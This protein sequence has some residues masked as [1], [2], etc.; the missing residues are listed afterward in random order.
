MI[1]II[2]G[3]VVICVMIVVNVN[4]NKRT[5][6][7]RENQK[8]YADRVRK[9]EEEYKIKYSISGNAMAVNCIDFNNYVKFS[10]MISKIWKDSD[11]LCMVSIDIH[12]NKGK[13]EIP[14]DCIKSYKR[15]GDFHSYSEV[16]GG[17]G[18]GSSIKG[19][20]VGGVLAGEVG[21]VIGSRKKV[22]EIKTEN[23]V[24]DKRQTILEVSVNDKTHY[25]VFESKD[26]DVFLKLIPNK[27]CSFIDKSSN[28]NSNKNI[29]KDIEELAKLK[30]KGI[31]STEEFLE[32][33]EMLLSKIN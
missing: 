13:V 16:T 27:E 32:K 7:L 1:W 11:K 2:F 15:I 33:K 12:S 3:I 26:Y 31:L 23:V 19:A 9:Q 6:D 5:E 21:A 24:V 30:D 20:V 28:E 8:K 22:N 18:G 10:N 25:L 4:T 17:G 14:I 29:F